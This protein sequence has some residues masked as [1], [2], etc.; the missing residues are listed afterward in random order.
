MQLLSIMKHPLH[1]STWHGWWYMLL[2]SF[3][4]GCVVW[5]WTTFPHSLRAVKAENVST[6][7]VVMLRVNI[8]QWLRDSE[9]KAMWWPGKKKSFPKSTFKSGDPSWLSEQRH[10]YVDQRRGRIQVRSLLKPENSYF[11]CLR[12]NECFPIPSDIRI[13]TNAVT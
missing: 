12:Y 1:M 11:S 5:S 13:C 6:S 7:S 2:F 4:L 3:V 9:Q 8:S 10:Y